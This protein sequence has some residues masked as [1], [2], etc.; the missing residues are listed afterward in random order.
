MYCSTSAK[1]YFSLMLLLLSYKQVSAQVP[2]SLAVY[3]KYIDEKMEAHLKEYTELVSIPSISSIPSKKSDVAR[4]G[5]WIVNKLTSVGFTN[6]Q[7]I[8]TE[9]NPVVYASW[10]KATGKPTVLIYAHYDIQP[11]K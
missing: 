10:N 8:P 5:A 9:G 4:A 11:V 6:A 7:L 1:F 2:P 3:Q